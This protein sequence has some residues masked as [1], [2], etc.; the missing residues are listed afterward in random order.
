MASIKT[1][2]ANASFKLTSQSDHSAGAG[3]SLSHQ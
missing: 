2:G 3:H 1:G